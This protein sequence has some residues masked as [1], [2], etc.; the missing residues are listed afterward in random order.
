[1]IRS[2]T[3]PRGVRYPVR[4]ARKQRP[5]PPVPRGV[6]HRGRRCEFVDFFARNLLQF[7][8]KCGILFGSQCKITTLRRQYYGEALKWGASRPPPVADKGRRASG[9]GQNLAKRTASNKFW[10]PQQDRRGVTRK[11]TDFVTVYFPKPLAALAF[12]ELKRRKCNRVLYSFLSKFRQLNNTEKY[13]SGRRGV[14]RNL[15]GR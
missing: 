3:V 2:A 8:K 10:A 6:R 4:G 12:T 1:M 7:S 11:Q 14:T 13:S 9:R 5:S 15:V